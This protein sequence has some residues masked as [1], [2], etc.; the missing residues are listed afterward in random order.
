[1]FAKEFGWTADYILWGISEAELNQL[2]HGILINKG[3]N[4]VKLQNKQAERLIED[5]FDEIKK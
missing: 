3:F 2:E 1:M 4:V 5:F